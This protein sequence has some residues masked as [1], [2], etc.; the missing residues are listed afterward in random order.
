MPGGNLFS[1]DAVIAIAMIQ[2]VVA[3]APF[4]DINSVQQNQ[5]RIHNQTSDD[6]HK[7]PRHHFVRSS[8]KIE[9]REGIGFEGE[10]FMT[11]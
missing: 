2:A 6:Y 7:I 3:L 9:G 4:I 1:L 5:A 10:A 11:K 8:V